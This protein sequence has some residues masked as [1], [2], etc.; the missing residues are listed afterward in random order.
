[1]PPSILDKLNLP[2]WIVHLK[3]KE[4]FEFIKTVQKCS[5]SPEGKKLI[6]QLI[7]LVEDQRIFSFFRREAWIVLF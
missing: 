1:M 4:T 2:A 5:L 6:D 3:E 7:V